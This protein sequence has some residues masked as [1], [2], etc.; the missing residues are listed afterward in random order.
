MP[1]QPGQMLSH[2]RLVEKIGEGGM[3]VVW[4]AQDT[5]LGREVALKILPAAVADDA[6][7]LARFER[8]AKL[9][10][11]LN[12]SNIA[13]IHGLEESTGLR[14]LVMELI[15]GEDLARRLAREALTIEEALEIGR[16]IA[17]ALEAAHDRNVIHRDLKPANVKL[18]PNGQVKVLDFGL[19]KSVG[20]EAGGNDP[21][22]SPT[23]TQQMTSAG[24][25]LGTAAYM[26]PEQARG[27]PVDRRADV[28]AFGCLLFECLTRKQAFAGETVTET[29]AAVLHLEP[30]WS[31][32]PSRT[33]ARLRDLLERWLEKDPNNRPRDIGD[34][35]LEIERILA[36]GEQASAGSGAAGSP[37]PARPTRRKLG[38]IYGFAFVVLSLSLLFL[39]RNFRLVPGYNRIWPLIPMIAVIGIVIVVVL[40]GRRG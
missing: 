38:V 19:A 37:S 40:R 3:G 29:M 17:Q 33:P 8:E 21:S 13:A 39:L 26:S 18:L 7:R 9:L 28:W 27:K 14:F 4:L 15:P 5:K 22:Q 2:Y 25:V 1:V 31:A 12:H 20:S 30:D 24:M 11:S 34:A 23:L 6:E 32:L 10:A 16:Q 35:R 36:E